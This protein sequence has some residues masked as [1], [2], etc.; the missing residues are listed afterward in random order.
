MLRAKRGCSKG[1]YK[2]VR[3][4][5]SGKYHEYEQ[6][7]KVCERCCQTFTVRTARSKKVCYQCVEKA[8]EPKPCAM[9]GKTIYPT[10][11]SNWKEY[12]KRKYCRHCVPKVA[13]RKDKECES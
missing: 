11:R 13:R 2:P 12:E 8:L 1:Y 6:V 7:E 5:M 4:S 3:F 10:N 9:C